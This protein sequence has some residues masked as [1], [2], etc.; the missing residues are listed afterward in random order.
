VQ[1]TIGGVY[2]GG[3]GGY[4]GDGDDNG[5]D[6]QITEDLAARMPHNQL[7]ASAAGRQGAYDENG[8]HHAA[9][10]SMGAGQWGQQAGGSYNHQMSAAIVYGD[11][12]ENLPG[13]HIEDFAANMG[14]PPISPGPNNLMSPLSMDLTNNSVDIH[15]QQGLSKGG[16]ERQGL[17]KPGAPQQQHSTLAIAAAVP[18]PGMP[19]GGITCSIPA[20][21]TLVE[22]DEEAGLDGGDSH[23]SLPDG[24][25]AASVGAEYRH[26]MTP[27]ADDHTAGMELTGN[28]TE[29]LAGAAGTSAAAGINPGAAGNVLGIAAEVALPESPVPYAYG[30]GLMGMGQRPLTQQELDLVVSPATPFMPR[31]ENSSGEGEGGNPGVQLGGGRADDTDDL[32]G[33][34]GFTPGADDT[35]DVGS[36][37]GFQGGGMDC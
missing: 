10:S 30:G 2:R 16:G 8:M 4:G 1:D 33:K 24:H 13:L 21:S 17:L 28:H 3:R 11:N 35:L 22:E 14:A 31:G 36:K 5:E 29:S 20:L 27:V 7:G 23:T 25:R 12:Q 34:W 26:N 32:K 15:H 6:M 19:G 9:G 18:L 37:G